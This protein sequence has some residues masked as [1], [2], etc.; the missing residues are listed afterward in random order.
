MSLFVLRYKEKGKSQ[1]IELSRQ[2][3]TERR[4]ELA[5]QQTETWYLTHAEPT[6]AARAAKKETYLDE[7]P[8]FIEED[9]EV[10][11]TAICDQLLPFQ[12]IG[13]AHV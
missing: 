6:V 9:F 11:L 3:A 12:E 5:E 7:I 1:A 13:R 4:E 10:G 8:E 2:A